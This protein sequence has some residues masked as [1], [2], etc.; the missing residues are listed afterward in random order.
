MTSD[1]TTCSHVIFAEKYSKK[2]LEDVMLLIDLHL[3]EHIKFEMVDCAWLFH[4]LK[5]KQILD[6]AEYQYEIKNEHDVGTWLKLT[7]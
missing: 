2:Y 3:Y 7:I 6:T 5:K 1:L 4:S